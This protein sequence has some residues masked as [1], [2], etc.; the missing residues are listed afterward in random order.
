MSTKKRVLCII[1]LCF[2]L[3]AL[4]WIVLYPF[5]GS[6]Y[7]YKSQLFP[8][9]KVFEQPLL[10]ESLPKD[11][12]KSLL[13][14]YNKLKE[15]ATQPKWTEAAVLFSEI[16]VYELC[17]VLLAISIPLFLLL[18]IEGANQLIWLLPIFCILFTIENSKNEKNPS[19]SIPSEA[20]LIEKYLKEPLSGS[21]KIQFEQLKKAW[22]DYLIVEFG[23]ENPSM[24]PQLYEKQKDKAQF[25]FNVKKIKESR[26]IPLSFTFQ[27]RRSKLVLA[28]YVLWNF[29]FAFFARM[30]LEEKI[31]K[32]AC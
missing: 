27:E 4:L 1:Q 8:F 6:I 16:S 18:K 5:L 31:D 19:I 15:L 30:I 9:E 24:V 10:F 13:T 21:M 26:L 28:F 25:L 23:Q 32:K 14:K 29:L 7:H 2:G 22:A 17:W 11:E 3:I 12:Q 20:Y